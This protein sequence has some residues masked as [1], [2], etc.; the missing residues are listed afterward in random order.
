MTWAPSPQDYTCWLHR[1]DQPL[2]KPLTQSARIEKE[3]LTH[4]PSDE[5]CVLGVA[6]QARVTARY[7]LQ[8]VRVSYCIFSLSFFAIEISLTI[9]NRW[10]NEAM[11]CATSGFFFLQNSASP[12]LMG[13]HA[14]VEVASRARTRRVKSFVGKR[15]L[16]ISAA[17]AS[18]GKEGQ[19]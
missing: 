6:S 16:N 9:G 11:A 19:D 1:R 10:Q 4:D 7:G 8:P 15:M 17:G 5:L 12:L 3:N 18:W 13:F 2:I 14:T